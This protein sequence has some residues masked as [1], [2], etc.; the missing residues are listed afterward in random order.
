MIRREEYF[1][2]AL[3][4]YAELGGESAPMV[5]MPTFT[6]EA[7]RKLVQFPII[8]ERWGH[9]GEALGERLL[10]GDHGNNP[11]G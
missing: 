8:V 6:G 5:L 3:S 4:P 9:D 11:E 2:T 10:K 1:D 7:F